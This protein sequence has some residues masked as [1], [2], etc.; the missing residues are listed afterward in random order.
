[1]LPFSI[2]AVVLIYTSIMLCVGWKFYISSIP[3]CIN[4]AWTQGTTLYGH[5]YVM[6]AYGH[7][8]TT[9]YDHH[10]VVCG[11]E[12]SGTSLDVHHSVLCGVN[13]LTSFCMESILLY[14]S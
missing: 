2:E 10:S 5:H 3:C 7:S 4:V 13:T 9:L 11:Y 14:F 1:M 8:S 12:Y 6:C